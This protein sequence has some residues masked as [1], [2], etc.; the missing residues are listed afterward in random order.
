MR[1][2]KAVAAIAACAL[3]CVPAVAA[4]VAAETNRSG[5]VAERLSVQ[6][7]PTRP[8]VGLIKVEGAISPATAGYIS[9]AITRAEREQMECLII[10]L[11]TPGGLLDSTKVIVQRFLSATVPVVVYVAPP[12][13]HAASAGCFITLAADIAAMAPATSIGAAHPVAL[14]GAP[15]EKEKTD[16]VMKQKLEN[17]AV[18]FIETIAAKRKRNVEWAKASVKESAALPAEKALATNVI[19]LIAKDLPD[20]LK[21]LDGRDVNGKILRTAEAE[22]VEIGMTL[23][24]RV[25]QML[26][27]PEVLFILMLI[28]IYGIIA[29]LNNP[30]AIFPGVV[31]AIALILAL[32]LAAILPINIAGIALIVLAIGLFIADV[33]ATTHGILTV[34]GVVSFFLG[35]LM[36][37]D[38]TEPAYRLSLSIILPATVVTALFFIFVIGAGLRAQLLPVRAG[39]EAL[40][41]KVVRAL[42]PIDAT[43]GRVFVE[44]EYWNAISE[45][46]IEKGQPV[47]IIG[48]EGLTLKVKPKETK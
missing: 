4:E 33:Y 11:D 41:G 20:L 45:V 8:R 35:A 16:E 21:Q 37:F 31:G 2:N 48:I 29:E 42:E 22:L 43:G 7:E 44:G 19:D 36:L 13:A 25:F 40:I 6:T 1:L 32:Y 34:G 17:F 5:T 23:R 3:L 14:G 28:A 47:E 46:A 12:G 24:E 15:G 9:R 18:S 30:G 27:R 39:R 10:Q 38:R 26:G